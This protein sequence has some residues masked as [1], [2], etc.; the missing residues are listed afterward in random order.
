MRP[1]SIILL[2]LALGCG[3]VASIGINQVLANR[4][5]IEVAPVGE[6]EPIFVVSSDVGMGEELTP[7]NIKLEAWPKDKVPTGAMTKLEE[8]E[9][10]RTRTRL[11]AGE[12]V[13]EAK[14]FSQGASAQGGSVLIPKGMRVV[15]VKV[16]NVSSSSGMIL[17]GDRVDVLVH[18]VANEGRGIPQTATRTVLQD[19]KVFAVN[20]LYTRDPRDKDETSISAKTI[21]LLVTPQQAE[22]I[23]LASEIGTI[24]LT[25]RSLEDDGATEAGGAAIDELLGTSKSNRADESLVADDKQKDD[26]LLSLLDGKPEPKEEPAAAPAPGW[27]MLL[28]RGENAEQVEFDAGGGLPLKVTQDP[29]NPPAAPV[30]S[31]HDDADSGDS[32]SADDGDDYSDDG[33]M[34]GPDSTSNDN[35]G[36]SE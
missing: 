30:S 31:D 2:V 21:S 23:T 35:H 27:K 6:T 7:E 16:D 20:D 19:V 34:D 14:L 4:G 5:K 3:L 28:L 10:R 29:A 24:R 25:M 9:G 22:L 36:E 33:D 17:P 11:Y 18:M 15:S 13:L 26:S 32:D 1:K 12:P 8:I